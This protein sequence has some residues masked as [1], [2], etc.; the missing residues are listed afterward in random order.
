[1]SE[2]DSNDQNPSDDDGSGQNDSTHRRKPN[3]LQM[4][5]GKLSVEAKSVDE[6]VGELADIV[7]DEMESL[8]R[9]HI[10]GEMEMLE[11]QDLHS[12]L[13]SDD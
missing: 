6:S 11:E 9:Y 5:A 10:R 13:L 1:M 12:I 4:R 2:S 8:M 7:S 3:E